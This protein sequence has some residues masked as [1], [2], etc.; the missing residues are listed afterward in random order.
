MGSGVSGL[1]AHEVQPNEN[2]RMWSTFSKQSDGLVQ[3]HPDNG[4]VHC[5]GAVSD[6]TSRCSLCFNFFFC[7]F[8]LFVCL[9][10]FLR[11]G[12]CLSYTILYIP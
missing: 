11:F 10:V 7:F 6:T 9:F 8:C 3:R 2:Y 5:K 1:R 4:N 12:I